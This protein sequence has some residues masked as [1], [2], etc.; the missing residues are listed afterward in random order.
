MVPNLLVL[1]SF[2]STP[3]VAVSVSVA[4]G[5]PAG[6]S[7]AISV[8]TDAAPFIMVDSLQGSPQLGGAW[9]GP[10]GNAHSPV[11][12]PGIDPSGA[13]CY[14]VGTDT[15]CLDVTASIAPNAGTDAFV[16]I[17]GNDPPTSY[18]PFLGGNPDTGGTWVQCGTDAICYVVPGQA[19]CANDTARVTINVVQPPDAGLNSVISVCANGTPLLLFDSIPGTP[20]L[21]G[22][23]TLNGAPFNG[24]FLPGVSQ[25]GVYCYAVQGAPPC[26][27]DVS[28]HTVSV[29]PGSD[30]ACGPLAAQGDNTAPSFSYWPEPNNGTL[31][32]QWPGQA[33][34]SV[35]LLDMNGRTVWMEEALPSGDLAITK[36]PASLPNGRYVLLL[37]TAAGLSSR[38]SITVIR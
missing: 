20:W 31:A 18:F 2:V 27:S 11:F 24:I 9:F 33:V 10:N 21:N 19:P 26:A 22:T 17:C 1:L 8:C 23:W 16:A 37:Y 38:A 12:V 30:P 28:C 15:A 3:V 35:R 6:G 32:V 5:G 25:P 34:N 4:P 29:L 14:V 13:Y 36:L 7:N